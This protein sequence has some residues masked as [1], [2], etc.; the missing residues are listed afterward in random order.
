M[1]Q[2][3]NDSEAKKKKNLTDKNSIYFITFLYI[4][5]GLSNTNYPFLSKKS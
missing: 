4:T 1:A 3:G 5:S 2:E